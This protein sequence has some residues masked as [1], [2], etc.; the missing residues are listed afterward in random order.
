MEGAA[1][2]VPSRG[3]PG[4]AAVGVSLLVSGGSG[5]RSAVTSGIGSGGG[6]VLVSCV[7]GLGVSG[8]EEG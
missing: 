7:S 5:G 2:G 3:M 6:V 8:G 1:V 4:E